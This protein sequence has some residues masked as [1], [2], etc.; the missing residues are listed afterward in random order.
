MTAANLQVHFNIISL[1]SGALLPQLTLGQASSLFLWPLPVC[2][3]D[4]NVGHLPLERITKQLW[5]ASAAAELL[6]FCR[7]KLDCLRNCCG[8]ENGRF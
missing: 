6:F 2:D 5:N 8:V 7:E 3:S 4:H 1:Y